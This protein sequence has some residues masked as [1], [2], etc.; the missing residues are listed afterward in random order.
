[1]AAMRVALLPL[2]L[3]GCDIVLGLDAPPE[4]PS[5]DEES[6]THDE[7]DDDFPDA[8]DLCPH[9][10]APETRDSDDDD[11]GD[12]C[13]PRPNLPDQRFFFAFED[14]GLGRLV[15]V[16]AI[17]SEADAVVLGATT[18]EASLTLALS[19]GV[20]DLV[21]GIDVLDHTSFQDRP[22]AEIGFF[23]VNR[24]FTP[25]K[26]MRGDNCFLGAD[27]SRPMYFEFNNDAQDVPNLDARFEEPLKGRRGRLAMSRDDQ[28]ISCELRDEQ[29]IY[30]SGGP[31]VT[32]PRQLVGNV[33]VTTENARVR[34]AYLFVVT[35]RP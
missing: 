21:A 7:D 20:V 27:P 25:E 13:D 26:T 23:A 6:R 17:E 8:L 22:Y 24:A 9:D 11:I 28:Q 35:P 1:M 19:A 16:G 34:L 30:A 2:F 29:K 12:R 4:V 32:V 31:H 5:L 10:P 18:T 15:P 33:A 14:G 3:G